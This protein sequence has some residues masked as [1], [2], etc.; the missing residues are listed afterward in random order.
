MHLC[1]HHLLFIQLQY[2]QFTHTLTIQENIEIKTLF[3]IFL[4]QSKIVTTNEENH[5]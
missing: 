4:N 3:T 1:Y 5:K 2:I